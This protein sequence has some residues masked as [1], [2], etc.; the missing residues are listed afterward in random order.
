MET[1]YKLHTDL[2]V[3]EFI[4]ILERSTLSERRPV[5]DLNAMQGML[6]KA[7]IIITASQGDKIVGIARSVSDFNYCC[8]L[9]DLAV[10]TAYQGQ[11]IGKEL[12]NKTQK[13]LGEHCTLI[14]IS[15]PAAVNYYPKIGLTKHQSTWTLARDTR[16]S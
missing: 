8:Y 14:L 7:D 5:H 9:S 2:R 4:D 6:D 3:A 1:K 16:L 15:A 11:G 12:I 13:E 10:D